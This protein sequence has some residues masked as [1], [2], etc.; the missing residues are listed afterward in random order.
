MSVFPDAPHRAGC[1]P[2]VGGS[3]LSWAGATWRRTS[4]GKAGGWRW[5]A[6]CPGLM[7]KAAQGRVRTEVGPSGSGELKE[8]ER[9]PVESPRR[10]SLSHPPG[11]KN[12]IRNFSALISFP[13][14]TLSHPTSLARG[15]GGIVF[16]GVGG[17]RKT[18]EA[19]KTAGPLGG[20]KGVRQVGTWDLRPWTLCCSVAELAPGQTSPQATK[21]KETIR[22]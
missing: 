4:L 7:K 15:S 21:Y 17:R 12:L 13:L 1:V 5:T 6:S 16:D 19:R 9:S 2:A 18:A 10:E 22:D 8:R 14:P 3:A 20:I 11:P